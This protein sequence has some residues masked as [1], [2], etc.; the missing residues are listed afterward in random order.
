MITH[1]NEGRRSMAS[2]AYD[3]NEDL[4]VKF[5]ILQELGE[6]LHRS[7]RMGQG[8]SARRVANGLG[9]SQR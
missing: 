1:A 3:R 8:Q 5:A 7:L 4:D 6:H 2:S 9:V